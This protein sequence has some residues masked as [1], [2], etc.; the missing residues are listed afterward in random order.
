MAKAKY[1]VGKVTTNNTSDYADTSV[2]LVDEKGLH[3]GVA[4]LKTKPGTG[5]HLKFENILK[6]ILKEPKTF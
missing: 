3:V 4:N 2:W 5:L 6:A 1:K